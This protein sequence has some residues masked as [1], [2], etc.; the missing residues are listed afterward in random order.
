MI[1][2]G[3]YVRLYGSVNRCAW[4]CG[5]LGLS[6]DSYVEVGGPVVFELDLIFVKMTLEIGNEFSDISY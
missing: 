4:L 1:Q 2:I 6:Y 5:S 3:K